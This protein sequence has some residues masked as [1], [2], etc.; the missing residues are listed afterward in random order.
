MSHTRGQ[1]RPTSPVAGCLVSAGARPVRRVAA[2]DYQLRFVG[3][4]DSLDAVT[5]AELGE[6]PAN[7]DLHCALGQAQAGRDFA[8]GHACGDVGEDFLLTASEDLPDAGGVVAAGRFG[9][10]CGGELADQA[11]RGARGQD[12]LT[13]GD[14]AD[15][16]DQVVGLGVFEQEAVAPAR[17]PA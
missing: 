8:V 4:N 17:S 6:Y 2:R 3:Q 11:L 12:R 9:L 16:V 15:R 10:L 7:M 14:R 1:P 5:Q 13:S